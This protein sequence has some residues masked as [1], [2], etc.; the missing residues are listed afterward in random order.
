VNAAQPAAP[1]NPRRNMPETNVNL[2]DDL[3][4]EYEDDYDEDNDDELDDELFAV[5]WVADGATTLAEAAGL[6]RAFADEL[7]ELHTQGYVLRDDE[8]DNGMAHYYKP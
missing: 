1:V 7:Q 5:K 2:E 6:V 8:I 3:D 4:D